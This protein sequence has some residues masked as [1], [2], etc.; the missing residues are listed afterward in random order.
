M[1]A[2]A[3]M[4]LVGVLVPQGHT[5]EPGYE[6]V[7]PQAIVAPTIDGKLDD[8]IW[9]NAKPVE[10][11]NINEGGEVDPDQFTKSW[12]TYDDKFLYVA[13][14][15]MEPHP[16]KLT[17]AAGGHDQDVWKD[18]EDEIFMEPSHSGAGPYY[19]IMINSA[20][21]TQDSEDGGGIGGAWEPD[22]Q[23]ATAVY[24]DNWVLEIRIP[25]EDM[26]LKEAP[27]GE[28]WGWN[29]NRHI[30]SG[31]DIWVCWATTGP[32]FH[33]PARFGDLTFGI[34]KLAVERS[35]KLAATWGSIKGY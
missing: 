34:E 25:F 13:F 22:I 17:V 28:T 14:E 29:F 26:D 4:L 31:D 27:V 24:K 33:T 10:W 12:A 15:N 16:G 32:S 7:I 35:H 9:K 6:I 19:H 2:A 8:A 23:S 5:H 30:M 3:V 1:S 20:N 21:T 11:G 18:D